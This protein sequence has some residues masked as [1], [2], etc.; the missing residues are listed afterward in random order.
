MNFKDRV[1]LF[2]SPQNAL[3]EV[4]QKYSQDFLSGEDVLTDNNFKMNAD[5]TMGFTA[6]FA[7]NR[8][9]SETLASCP[10]MLYEKQGIT[11]SHPNDIPGKLN[12]SKRK[13]V[14]IHISNM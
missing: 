3:F 12:M 6:V 7:C 14:F 10:I 8:V 9:L 5:S 11:L 1:K 13:R 2:L 4:L